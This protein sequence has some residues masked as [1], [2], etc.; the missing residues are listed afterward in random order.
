[1]VV[2][3]IPKQ[4]DIRLSSDHK[5]YAFSTDASSNHKSTPTREDRQGGMIY[6][7]V[8]QKA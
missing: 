4:M 8:E 3:R 7:S 1:M 6:K 5:A 2:E